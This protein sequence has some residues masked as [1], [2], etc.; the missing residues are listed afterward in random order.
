MLSSSHVYP[1]VALF[2][3]VQWFTPPRPSPEKDINMYVVSRMDENGVRRGDI[4]PM[5]SI[6][7]FVQLIPKYGSVAAPELTS[8]NSMDICRDYYVNSFADKQNYQFVW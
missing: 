8:K 1:A 4:I 6:A 5:S 3:Y 7:R 2:A